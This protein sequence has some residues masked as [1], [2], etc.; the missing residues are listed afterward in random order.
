M[1]QNHPMTTDV[2]IQGDG[3]FAKKGL[4]LPAET[5]FEEWQAQGAVLGLMHVSLPFWI[6]DWRNFGEA[7]FGDRNYQVKLHGVKHETEMAYSWVASRIALKDRRL[8]DLTFSH[9]RLVAALPRPERNTWLDKA[10][11][12]NWNTRDFRAALLVKKLDAGAEVLPPDPPPAS[13]P[14]YTVREALVTIGADAHWRHAATTALEQL[15]ALTC[16][17]CGEEIEL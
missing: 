16:P 12:E 5:S 4:V 6:G 15:D 13:A 11:R 14:A 7:A 1:I 8:P 3:V 17:H 9:H 10:V 2:A